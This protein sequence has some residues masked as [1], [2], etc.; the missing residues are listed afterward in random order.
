[1]NLI[2]SIIYK[3]LLVDY[4]SISTNELRALSISIFIFLESIIVGIIFTPIQIYAGGWI[5]FFE[6][7][8]SLFERAD[9]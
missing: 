4:K 6:R 9:N 2:N 8:A 5:L 7:A 3:Y 1:M